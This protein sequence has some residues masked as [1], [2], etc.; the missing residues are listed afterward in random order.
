[1]KRIVRVTR[2]NSEPSAVKQFEVTSG[3]IFLYANGILQT[4]F[5]DTPDLR[6]MLKFNGWT[7]RDGSVS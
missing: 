6:E 4:H 7:E 3:R 5:P 2:G 1:M